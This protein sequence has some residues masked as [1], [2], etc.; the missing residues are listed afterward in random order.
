MGVHTISSGAMDGLTAF[1]SLLF[2][3]INC[4]CYGAGQAVPAISSLLPEL[5]PPIKCSVRPS[6]SVAQ[7]SCYNLVGIIRGLRWW[8]SRLVEGKGVTV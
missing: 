2:S 6:I 7:Y 4:V 3:I 8:R 5:Y 1:L